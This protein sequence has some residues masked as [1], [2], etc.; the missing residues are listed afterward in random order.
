M[1]SKLGG[2]KQ[3]ATWL[4]MAISLAMLIMTGVSPASASSRGSTASVMA[5]P[6]HITIVVYPNGRND[7]SNLQLAFNTCVS[8][9]P[10]CTVQLVPGTYHIAQIT[11]YGFEGSF[12]GAGQGMTIVKGLP[13]LPSPA[14]AYNTSST[15]FWAGLP[16]P[17]N[18][19]PELFTFVNGTFRI[20]G[21]TVTDAYQ[22]PTMGWNYLGANYTALWASIGITGEEATVAIDHVTMIGGPGDYG[23]APYLFN[24]V[25]ASIAYGGEFLPPGWSNPYAFI[26]LAGSLSVTDSMFHY[27]D[28]AVG[29]ASVVNATM[30]VCFNTV[31]VS[32]VTW[33]FID[34]SNSQAVLCGNQASNVRVGVGAIVLQSLYAQDQPSAVY[35]IGNVFRDVN[36][37][38]NGVWLDDFGP[39]NFGT[40]PTLSAVLS[41]NV[42]Q[43]NTSCGCYGTPPGVVPAIWSVSLESVII[44][45]NTLQGG[46]GIVLAGSPGVIS[47]NT[48]RGNI[49]GVELYSTNFTEVTNN[50]IRNSATYGI[51]LFAGSGNNTVAHNYVK[52][53]GQYD[54]Y[55]DGTGSNNVWIGNHFKTSSPPGL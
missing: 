44:S 39:S 33:G 49:V 48:L 4:V 55:W 54:L 29:V 26:P 36:S 53:S 3:G 47:G 10:W 41:G 45:Y 2:K 38:A 30:E 24:D 7:T 50:V 25:E 42:I 46:A 51:A 19:W 35:I 18:P 16:G 8:F 31:T 21:M 6:S 9:G 20:S 43:T 27:V 12:V 11:V 22:N 15:P 17:N 13:N 23:I 34:M 40:P 32:S 52:N 14:A 37:D 5:A 28:T 1:R